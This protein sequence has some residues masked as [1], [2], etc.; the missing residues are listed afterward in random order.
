LKYLAANNLGGD[1]DSARTAEAKRVDLTILSFPSS[2]PV[3]NNTMTMWGGRQNIGE[4]VL[5][6]HFEREFN[7]AAMHQFTYR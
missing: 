5:T 7:D 2:F 1:L 3:G 4:A 6:Q